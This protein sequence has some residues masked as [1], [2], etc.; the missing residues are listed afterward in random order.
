MAKRLP[1]YEV[2]GWEI[3]KRPNTFA[4]RFAYEASAINAAGYVDAWKGFQTLRDARAF[5][6]AT[7]KP[8]Q[9]VGEL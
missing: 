6:E 2:N 4:E 5:C 9:R 8:E 3:Q 7:A 1:V